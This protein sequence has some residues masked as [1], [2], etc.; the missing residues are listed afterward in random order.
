MS[1]K[2]VFLNLLLL[3]TLVLHGHLIY[4]ENTGCKTFGATSYIQKKIGSKIFLP[5]HFWLHRK[6]LLACQNS[7]WN[8]LCFPNK[9]KVIAGSLVS[10]EFIWDTFRNALFSVD[11]SCLVHVSSFYSK[12]RKK[13][14]RFVYKGRDNVF[15]Y[16]QLKKIFRFVYRGR[17]NAFLYCRL[18]KIF[19]FVYKGRNNA[20]KQQKKKI[21]LICIVDL[22]KLSDLYIEVEITFFCIV[23]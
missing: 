4:S 1:M 12:L 13:I 9:S 15:L 14:F 6:M 22:R 23:D 17:N 10:E 8:E 18:N 7:G 3:S 21:T 5:L 19:W 11:L 16:C 2:D 20:K